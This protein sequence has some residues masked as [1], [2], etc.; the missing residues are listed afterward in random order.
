MK[1]IEKIKGILGLVLLTPA[2]ISVIVFILQLFDVINRPFKQLGFDWTGGYD[3]G[4]ATSSLPF[5]FGL[6]GIAGALLLFNIK[7]K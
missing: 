6:M 4:G 1:H 2:I 5:Y 3:Q 7:E